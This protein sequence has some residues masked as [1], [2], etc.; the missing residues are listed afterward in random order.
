MK[1]TDHALQLLL[2]L[3]VLNYVYEAD[4]WIKYAVSAALERQ[5]VNI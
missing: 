2:D 3:D 1:G 4:Y 5:G